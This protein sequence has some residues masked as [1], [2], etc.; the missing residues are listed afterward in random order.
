MIELRID[1]M[2]GLEMKF[3]III[4]KKWLKIKIIRMRGESLF[5]ILMIMRDRG[6]EM[7]NIIKIEGKLFKMIE[8]I[9]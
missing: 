8:N 9:G 6:D 5:K 1:I 4:K 2:I 7:M 3:I